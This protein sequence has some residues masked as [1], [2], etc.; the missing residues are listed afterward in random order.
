MTPSSLGQLECAVEFSVVNSERALV[1]EKDFERTDAARNDF[2][3]L[4]LGAV[5]ELGSRPCEM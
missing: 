5:V 3:Q 1:G 2:A 4:R